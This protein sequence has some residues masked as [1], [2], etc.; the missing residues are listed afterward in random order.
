MERGRDSS[1]NPV[2]LVTIPLIQ[3]PLLPQTSWPAN[4]PAT[5]TNVILAPERATVATAEAI[6]PLRRAPSRRNMSC[7]P[8]KGL[9]RGAGLPC[10]RG[11]ER[12]GIAEDEDAGVRR[13]RRDRAVDL[14][15][16]RLRPVDDRGPAALER[17]RVA[18]A[19]TARDEHVHVA[20]VVAT[21]RER[22][23]VGA[24]QGGAVDLRLAVVAA[25]RALR[26]ATEAPGQDVRRRRTRARERL[27]HDAVRRAHVRVRAVQV[28]P[29]AGSAAGAA[30]GDRVQRLRVPGRPH[31]GRVR[32]GGAVAGRPGSG[33]T[34][35]CPSPAENESPRA[36]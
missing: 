33:G 30:R 35:R 19:E 6:V 18:V 36:T 23:Q 13:L 32:P 12:L 8:W 28:G 5:G 15:E 4:L 34:V 20:G 7:S 21:E 11:G 16:P 26:H 27:P 9:K 14:L 3:A 22:D 24:G 1:P 25:R 10:L 2:E 31:P 17:A 29:A